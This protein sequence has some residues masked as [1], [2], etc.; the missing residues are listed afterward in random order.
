[1]FY[2]CLQEIQV[3]LFKNLGTWLISIFI[4]AVYR[5]KQFSAPGVK[6]LGCKQAVAFS[7]YANI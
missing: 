4:P 5:G 2:L 3:S 1:M 6:V 7:H